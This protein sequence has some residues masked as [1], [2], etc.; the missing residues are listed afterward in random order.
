MS[1]LVV[2]AF[3]EKHG[4]ETY[5]CD[6]NSAVA[7][8]FFAVMHSRVSFGY[9]SGEARNLAIDILNLREKND[10]SWV[11]KTFDFMESRRDH[12]YEGYTIS[13]RSIVKSNENIS[14]YVPKK[15]KYFV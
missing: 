10:M 12:E 1:D 7:W 2:I 14:H 11:E 5:L 13:F 9:Y 3:D 15:F 4:V 6:T 8:V